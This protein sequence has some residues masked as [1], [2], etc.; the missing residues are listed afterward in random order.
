M[1]GACQHRHPGVIHT[2]QALQVQVV[3]PGGD[4]A[5]QQT[6][7]QRICRRATVTVAT[8][9]QA[10][11]EGGSRSSGGVK[12][13]DRAVMWGW[14]LGLVGTGRGVLHCGAA[15]LPGRGWLP[16]WTVEGGWGL[17]AGTSRHVLS[18]VNMPS[19]M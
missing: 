17:C 18:H 12:E 6:Q 13:E 4:Q 19:K 14:L 15:A 8:V 16:G 5:L 2:R 11:K 9:T 1:P 10:G 7:G 3:Q